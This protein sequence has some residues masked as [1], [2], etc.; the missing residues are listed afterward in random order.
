MRQAQDVLKWFDNMQNP[1][2]TW[3]LSKYEL[4]DILDINGNKTGRVIERGQPMYDGE[5]N[6]VV[7]ENQTCGLRRR[8]KMVGVIA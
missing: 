1:V 7:N 6:G 3:Y 5:R 8:S 2:P 4:W